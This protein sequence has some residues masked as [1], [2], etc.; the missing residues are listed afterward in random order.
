[1]RLI[2]ILLLIIVFVVGLLFLVQNN[3]ALEVPLA[4]QFNLF[5]DGLSWKSDGVPF[6]FVVIAAFAAGSLL[7]MVLF[8]MERISAELSR[9]E[10]ERNEK[11]MRK[12]IVEENKQ[13]AKEAKQRELDAKQAK[14]IA[15]APSPIDVGATP[16]KKAD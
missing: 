13:S 1:M 15:V 7:T 14:E 6:Y 16:K 8:L 9:M 3:A 10:H 11:A 5:L 12:K 4:L 2:R